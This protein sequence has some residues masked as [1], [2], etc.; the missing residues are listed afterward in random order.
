M[1]DPMQRSDPMRCTARSKQRGAQC[2]QRAIAGGT[3][4]VYHGGKAPQVQHA[5]EERLKAL[6]PKAVDVVEEMMAPDAPPVMRLAA[7]RE[8]FD[9]TGLG[10][11][12][13][14]TAG[15]VTFTLRIDRKGRDEE[16]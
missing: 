4:C 12:K 11:D 8:V 1:S 6:Q 15:V 10:K 5:A 9:R 2:R 14:P 7:A 13:Q 3:V 16:E